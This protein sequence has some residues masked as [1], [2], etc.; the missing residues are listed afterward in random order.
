MP[1]DAAIQR[2]W[3]RPLR[4]GCTYPAS[5]S[6]PTSCNGLASDEY[7]LPWNIA[8]PALGWSSPIMHRIVVLFPEP[9]GPRNPVT[10]PGCTS[11]LR[12]PTA[13]FAP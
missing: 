1:F 5:S 6:T 10:T 4:P 7:A 11:K 2:R 13:T 9:F 12:L 3:L 8:R